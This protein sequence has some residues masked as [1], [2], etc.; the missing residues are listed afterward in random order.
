MVG[1]LAGPSKAYRPKKSRHATD[2]VH[3]LFGGKKEPE[4][5]EQG[6]GQTNRN[7]AIRTEKNRERVQ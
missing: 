5:L 1:H 3:G 6:Y 2:L 7:R 4:D